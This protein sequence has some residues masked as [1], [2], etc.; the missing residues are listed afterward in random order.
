MTTNCALPISN[1]ALPLNERNEVFNFAF[2]IFFHTISPVPFSLLYDLNF[3]AFY[4][5]QS[6]L[7]QGEFMP[8]KILKRNPIC[9]MTFSPWCNNR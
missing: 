8:P 5:R 6:I 9:A 4:F 2:G 1:L 3:H 7:R